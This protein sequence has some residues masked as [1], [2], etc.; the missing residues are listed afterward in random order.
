[1]LLGVVTLLLGVVSRNYEGYEGLVPRLVRVLE[2]LR[3]KDVTPDYAYY[4][5]PSPW[6]QVT[7]AVMCCSMPPGHARLFRTLAVWSPLPSR[8]AVPGKYCILGLAQC[9]ARAALAHWFVGI[10]AGACRNIKV[11]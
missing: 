6:L 1:M 9:I 2:K 7:G 11:H 10:G 8:V 5:I 3:N 4:G